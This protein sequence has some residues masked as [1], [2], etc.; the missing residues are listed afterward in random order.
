MNIDEA[1]T[2]MNSLFEHRAKNLPAA[3]LANVFDHLIWCLDDNGA[4]IVA[5]RE[6]WLLSEDRE[7]VEIALAME[8]TYP[9]A[10]TAEMQ[11]AFAR[12][13][14]MWPSLHA[15]CEAITISRGTKE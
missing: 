8:E 15:R 3:A 1:A 9:F 14:L 11:A 13:S 10:T 2:V 12:I 7:R 5:V 6:Q 4:S